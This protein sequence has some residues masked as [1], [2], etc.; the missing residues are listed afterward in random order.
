MS[1]DIR[2]TSGL[3]LQGNVTVVARDAQGRIKAIRH[4]KNL[5]VNG[6]KGWMAGSLSGGIATPTNMKYIGVGTGSTAATATDTALGG[7]VETRATGTQ[8]VV[9][10]TTTNDTYQCIGTVTMTA[11]RAITESGLFGASTSGTMMSRNVFSVINL[12]STDT[13][14]VTWKIPMTAV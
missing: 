11:G 8:S 2:F 3:G 6:G 5:V 10:T 1:E 13:L 12:N 4:L 14:A 7:E 9:T